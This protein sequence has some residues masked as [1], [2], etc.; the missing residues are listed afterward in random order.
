MRKTQEEVKS[1]LETRRRQYETERKQRNKRLL[2]GSAALA[3]C[4]A[5]VLLLGRM[6][7]T[8]PKAVQG[9]SSLTQGP[10]GAPS[11]GTSHGV[12]PENSKETSFGGGNETSLPP[13]RPVGYDLMANVHAAEV[14]SREADDAF[15]QAQLEFAV[16]LLRG[17]IREKQNVLK[18]QKEQGVLTCPL[19]AELALAM[20][21]N[22][23]DGETLQQMEHVLGGG[24]PIDRLNEYLRTYTASLPSVDG[25]KLELANGIW[26]PSHVPTP[27][28]AFLQ[29]NADYYGAGAFQAPLEKLCGLINDWV[30]TN[31]DGM[32]KKLYDELDES[33]VMVL[34]NTVLFDGLWEETYAQDKMFDGKFF[35]YGGKI[36]P[37]TMMCSTES[38]YLEDDTGTVGFL[39]PY[40]NERYAFVALLPE[41]GTDILDYA[42]SLSAESLQN[43]LEN[44]R[45]T[46]VDAWLPKFTFSG[47]LSMK[48]LL[49]AMGM[50]LA[51]DPCAADFS[52]IFD[53]RQTEGNVFISSVKQKTAIEISETGTKAAAATGV[54]ADTESTNPFVNL[55]RPFVYMILDTETNLPLFLG[56]L[57]DIP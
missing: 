1:E 44:S 21:A 10:S 46:T 37:A 2:G 40:Q 54:T 5:V 11:T 12:Q 34:V 17:A 39:K 9:E 16:N 14:R 26:I 29:T 19:S 35:A 49:S 42:S 36:T 50:P 31:T 51:F 4:L 55:N 27:R 45:K 33:T 7:F 24:I 8:S 6:P 22:G 41:E 28:A 38:V 18:T 15:V 48:E 57:T 43:M 30:K 13:V 53:L 52:R 47:E 23:A 32:I 25:S 3:V 56:V 20:I